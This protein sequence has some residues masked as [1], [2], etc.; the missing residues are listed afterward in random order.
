MYKNV[1]RDFTSR[2]ARQIAD[3]E[4]ARARRRERRG[5]AAR[6]WFA[7]VSIVAVEVGALWM[8][9]RWLGLW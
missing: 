2:R 7:V 3:Q 8:L 6:A 4:S 5:Y 9:A 1:N